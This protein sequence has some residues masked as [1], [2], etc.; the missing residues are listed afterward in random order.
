M[1]W[2]EELDGTL[3]IELPAEFSYSECLVFLERSPLEVLH[4]IHDKHI[5]KLIMVKAELILIKISYRVHVLVIEFPDREPLNKGKIVEFIEN[6]FDL[7]Q[8]ISLFY[9][10]VSEDSLLQPLVKQYF[11]LRMIGIPDLFE[12]LTWAIMGQQINLTFAYTLKQRLVE[13][14]GKKRVLHDKDYWVYPSPEI[15]ASLQI[16]NLRKLQFTTRKAE[17]V[18]GV[19]REIVEGRLSKDVLRSSEDPARHLV[20]LRG[21]GPWT[22]DYVLMKC[23]LKTDAFPVAD[24]GL[25][26]AVMK[27]LGSQQKPTVKELKKQAENWSGWEAYATFYLWRSLYE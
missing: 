14:Y 20:S 7:N 6:W 15:I 13:S 2:T 12:A 1:R 21:I 17:Y 11:G 9:D 24:V 18:I 22:A 8:D 26:N 27:Q 25:Q 19:A 10:A 3:K 23:L 5:Y 4:H 16:E